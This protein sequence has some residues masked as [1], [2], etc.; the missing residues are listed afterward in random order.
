MNPQ[1]RR[2][3]DEL[4]GAALERE[5]GERDAFLAEACKRDEELRREVGGLAGGGGRGVWCA[6]DGL[7]TAHQ[8]A[9]LHRDIKPANILVAKNGYA[10]LADFGL[11]KIEERISPS[12]ATLT[13]GEEATRPGMI[14]GTVAYMSPEQASGRGVDARS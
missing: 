3:V 7:A 9:I 2:Q 4:Y 10:K 14:L 6:G 11:A 13:V 5:P 8:A 12:D 1:R